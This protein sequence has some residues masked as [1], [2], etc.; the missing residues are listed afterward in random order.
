MGDFGKAEK[1]ILG[2]MSE[3]TGFVFEGKEYTVGLSGKPTC[4]KGEPKTDIYILA[5]SDEDDA[6]IKI[7][8]NYK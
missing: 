8:Y 1:R 6:E 2:F 3:G 7:S 4:Q 5:K